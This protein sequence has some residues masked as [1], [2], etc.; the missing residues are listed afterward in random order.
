MVEKFLFFNFYYEFIFYKNQIY[1]LKEEREGRACAEQSSQPWFGKG[2]LGGRSLDRQSDA[3][4]PDRRTTAEP[5]LIRGP[6]AR[7]NIVWWKKPFHTRRGEDESIMVPPQWPPNEIVCKHL[8]YRFS[9]AAVKWSLLHDHMRF[10][11]LLKMP[12][13]F[14]SQLIRKIIAKYSRNN[15]KCLCF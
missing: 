5:D 1:K 11:N 8:L 9:N 12:S 6:V 2:T 13:V 15:F 14:L 10:G 7:S 3:W 4:G